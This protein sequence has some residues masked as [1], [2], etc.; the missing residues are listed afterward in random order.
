MTVATGNFPELLWPGIHKL[1]G[2][3]YKDWSPLFEQIFSMQKSDN[4]F[5]KVQGLTGLGLLVQKDQGNAVTYSDPK[6]GLQKEFV[7]VTYGLGSSVTREMFEDDQYS[8]INKIPRFLA[9][10]ARHTRETMAFNHLNRAF[11]ASYT[12]ADGLS[13]CNASHTLVMGGTYSNQLATPADLSQT[14]LE[15]ATNALMDHVDDQQLKINARPRKLVV[16]TALRHT[17]MK[18]LETEMVV[19]S[20]DNDKNTAKGLFSGPP[21]VSPWLTDPDAWFIIVDIGET[22]GL[23][24]LDRRPVGLERDNEFTT[25]SLRFQTSGRWSSGWVDPRGVYGTAGA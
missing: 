14:S 25:Q 16:P 23:V 4:A 8:Y 21:L 20:A 17:A 11:N 1:F 15:T 12:G 2:E 13:L 9:R 6:Q 7:N 19:G 3:R 22:D 18:L 24:W 5:E 10:S